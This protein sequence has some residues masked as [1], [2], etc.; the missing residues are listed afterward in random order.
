MKLAQLFEN[1]ELFESDLGHT[2]AIWS[3]IVS[4]YWA[5]RGNYEAGAKDMTELFQ[6][7]K[8]DGVD[9]AALGRE[10]EEHILATDGFEHQ[11][12]VATN[13]IAKKVFGRELINMQKVAKRIKPDRS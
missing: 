8:S 13:R 2:V 6:D 11:E 12:I 9:P 5:Q 3:E 1:R 7:L 4:D 10:M